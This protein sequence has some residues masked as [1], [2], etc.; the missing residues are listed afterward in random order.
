MYGTLAISS[1]TAHLKAQRPTSYGGPVF[2]RADGPGGI[3]R[4]G[5]DVKVF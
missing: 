4:H 2:G 5:D 1:F 3:V